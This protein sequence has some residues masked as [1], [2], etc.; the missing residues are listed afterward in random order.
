[1]VL[2]VG[3]RYGFD[4]LLGDVEGGYFRQVRDSEGLGEEFE[5]DIFGEVW[6]GEEQLVRPAGVVFIF[7]EVFFKRIGVDD[8]GALCRLYK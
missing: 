6:A 5:D 3:C 8:A 1:V 4:E 7:F 2:G